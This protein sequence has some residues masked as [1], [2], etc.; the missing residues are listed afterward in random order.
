MTTLHFLTELNKWTIFQRH[1]LYITNEDTHLIK[2]EQHCQQ[3]KISYSYGNNVYR[4]MVFNNQ[5]TMKSKLVKEPPMEEK[6]NRNMCLSMCVIRWGNSISATGNNI[7]L[8]SNSNHNN[9]IIMQISIMTMLL[10]NAIIS[11]IYHSKVNVGI[12]N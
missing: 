1:P 5:D 8:Q 10:Y 9:L 12:T 3:G 6:V 2:F 4:V 11:M 7:I